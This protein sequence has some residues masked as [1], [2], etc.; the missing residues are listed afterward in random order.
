MNGLEIGICIYSLPIYGKKLEAYYYHN[1]TKNNHN[2]QK[3]P[4]NHTTHTI[5]TPKAQPSSPKFH[6]KPQ[7]LIYNNK[8]SIHT[9]SK[10]LTVVNLQ[11]QTTKLDNPNTQVYMLILV[12]ILSLQ[13]RNKQGATQTCFPVEYLYKQPQ[14]GKAYN[15]TFHHAKNNRKNLKV[16]LYEV[17]QI[18]INNR[19]IFYQLTQQKN[20]LYETH[21]KDYLT[22]IKIFIFK[23]QQIPSTPLFNQLF[24]IPRKNAKQTLHFRITY[25]FSRLYSLHRNRQKF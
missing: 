22:S 7:L 14:R 6:A 12:N 16:S 5:I 13:P 10:Q 20:I 8:L 19:R 1:K 2:N 9:N 21:F 23:A 25:T 3:Q 17:Q 11:S 18:Q 4:K 15:S 24:T